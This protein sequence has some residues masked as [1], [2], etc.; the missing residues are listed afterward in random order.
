MNTANWVWSEELKGGRVGLSG[1]GKTAGLN[2]EGHGVFMVNVPMSEGKYSWK[3]KLDKMQNTF[4]IALGVGEKN[5]DLNDKI[6]QKSFWGFAPG[7]AR[8]FIKGSSAEDWG[9][10]A[11]EGDII[12]LELEFVNNKGMLS[13]S[14]NGESVGVLCSDLSPPLYPTAKLYYKEDQ[15]QISLVG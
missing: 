6:S 5:L 7:M 2:E 12:G 14:I 15:N 10:S 11:K 3:V 4:S 8:K 1:N 9:N 13:F